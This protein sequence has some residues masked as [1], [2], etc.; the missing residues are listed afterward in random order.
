MASPQLEDGFT[1]IANE[2]M[3]A[4][5]HAELPGVQTRIVLMIMRETYGYR[6]KL[7]RIGYQALSVR[8]R[9]ARTLLI[10]EMAKLVERNIL[11]KETSRDG[12]SWGIQKDYTAWSTGHCQVTSHSQETSHQNGELL[13]TPSGPV[14]SHSQETTLK[15]E[16]KLKK[17]AAIPRE[18]A[19]PIAAAGSGIDPEIV[20]RLKALTYDDGQIRTI[21]A[22][23]VPHGGFTL[24]DVELGE[25]WLDEQRPEWTGKYG[26]LYNT[27]KAGDVPI[28]AR[29]NGHRPTSR[30]TARL[31]DQPDLHFALDANGQQYLALPDGTRYEVPDYD[32]PRLSR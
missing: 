11:I 23:A 28:L 19:P 12:N 21:I 14:T 4:M 31:P 6:R 1:Q 9:M 24:S 3:V 29:T 8:Y 27:W 22:A 15:K 7:V 30:P 20:S 26:K 32:P 25:R 13:V 17:E 5:V 10:R 2:L 18:G 16:K